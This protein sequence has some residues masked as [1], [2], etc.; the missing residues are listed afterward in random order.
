M[1]KFSL[2]N[3]AFYDS[4][5]NYT[6]LPDDL[7]EITANQYKELLSA[8]NNGCIVFDNLAYSSPRPSQFHEWIGSEWVD[9]RTE[10]E[11]QEYKRSIYPTLTRY[12]FMR[13]LLALGYKSSYIEVQI[14]QIE[15]EF[16]RELTMLGFKDAT[17]FVRTDSSISVVRDILGKTDLEVDEFWEQCLLF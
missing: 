4:E 9:N 17:K 1:I 6:D 8:L 10:Q 3:K 12:Q 13:G 16:T 7:V 11:K 14:L 2:K 15:D 5:L